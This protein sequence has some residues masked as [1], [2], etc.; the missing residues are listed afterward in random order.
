MSYKI[1]RLRVMYDY[2]SL[3]V[4]GVGFE[5][6]MVMGCNKEVIVSMVCGLS[7]V[8]IKLG[9]WCGERFARFGAVEEVKGI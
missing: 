1:I 7:E 9:P 6:K 2:C 5:V 3:D 4:D 8:M